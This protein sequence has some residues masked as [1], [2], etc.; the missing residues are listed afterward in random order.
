MIQKVICTHEKHPGEIRPNKYLS[1]CRKN[2]GCPFLR[3]KE[4]KQ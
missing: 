1:K 3:I 2:G 4:V